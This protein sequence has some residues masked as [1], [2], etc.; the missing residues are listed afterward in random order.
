MFDFWS[1]L[2]DMI[3]AKAAHTTAY[4]PQANGV[5]EW[6]HRQMKASKGKLNASNWFNKLPLVVLGIRTALKKDIGCSQ[7]IWCMVRHSDFLENF[8]FPLQML[9]NHKRSLTSQE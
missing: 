3:G 1:Q 8:L 5:V 9:H 6:F 7:Q 2:L 4:Y